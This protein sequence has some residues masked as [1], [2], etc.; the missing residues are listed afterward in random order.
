MANFHKNLLVL[1]A[2]ETDMRKVLETFEKNLRQCSHQTGFQGQIE[3]GDSIYAAY[4]VVERYIDSWYQ[5]AFCPNPTGVGDDQSSAPFDLGGF[6][7]SFTMAA[8]GRALSESA[9]VNFKNIGSYYALSI[10][11]D[12]AWEPNSADLD[13]FFRHLPGGLYGIAFYHADEGDEY[14]SIG[15]ITGLHRG[16]AGL[17]DNDRLNSDWTNSEVLKRKH[18]DS[19]YADLE[20]ISDAVSLAE[21]IVEQ[22]WDE[23]GWEEDEFGNN[24]SWGAPSIN[25]RK[26]TDNDLTRIDPIVLEVLTS[27]P[28]IHEMNRYSMEEHADAIEGLSVGERVVIKSAWDDERIPSEYE[29]NSR[30]VI[31]EVETTKGVHLGR[32]HDYMNIVDDWQISD[33]APEVLACLLP[34]INAAVESLNPVSLRNA[35][36]TSPE[37]KIRFDMEPVDLDQII[38]EVHETLEMSFEKRSQ[39]SIRGEE[40]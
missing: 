38:L 25:W 2:D 20:S 36:V 13:Y 27:F 6:F 3:V 5:F 22:E 35:G 29:Y 11:Y 19:L 17:F 7:V 28:Q 33:A 12:T 15:K 16:S 24:E 1:V 21:T 9:T 4:S 14:E 26:P 40:E 18:Q 10:T 30:Y 23:F 39:T 34:H 37:M 31:F 32:L 8:S